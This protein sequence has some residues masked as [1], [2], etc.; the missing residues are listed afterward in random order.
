MQQTGWNG[1]TDN[2]SPPCA[3]GSWAADKQHGQRGDWKIM[4]GGKN[5]L[6]QQAV[7]VPMQ[8]V[9]CLPTMWLMPKAQLKSWRHSA[10]GLGLS[11]GAPLQVAPAGST[12]HQPRPAGP[13]RQGVGGVRCSAASRCMASF[14]EGRSSGRTDRHCSI[15]SF[16]PSGHSSGTEGMRR[17]PASCGK[18]AWR[19]WGWAATG[20]ASHANQ[21]AWMVQGSK[22]LGS[23]VA[24][25]TQ[26]LLAGPG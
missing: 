10:D 20:E 21:S 5:G 6:G 3:A 7:C 19:E 14:A 15:S 2:A 8:W 16:A 9:G 13:C 12:Q 25:A 11:T 4:E 1:D 26:L 23:G 24:T 17:R 22:L 18:G